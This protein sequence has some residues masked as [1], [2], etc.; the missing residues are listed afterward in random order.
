MTNPLKQIMDIRREEVP[1]AL[2]MSTYFFLVI[3]TFWV[4]RPLKTGLF[5]Q[6]YDQR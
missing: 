2:L 4:L 6:F 5:V 1:Q 3:A